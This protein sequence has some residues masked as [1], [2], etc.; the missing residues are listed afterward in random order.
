M[1]GITKPAWGPLWE[2]TPFYSKAVESIY[3]HD[4]NKAKQLLDAAGW[5]PGRDG[6]RTKNGRR[7]TVTLTSSDFTK[8]FEEVS[9]ANWKDVGIELQLQPMTVAAA[10]EAIQNNKVNSSPQAWV[11]SDPVVLTNLFHSKNIKGGFAWSKYSDPHLDQL[12]DSGEH[13]IHDSERATIYAEVQKIIMDNAL[14]VPYYGNPEA[15][16]AYE[17][18][19]QGVKQDFRNYLWLYDTH[20]K[21]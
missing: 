18:R 15:S 2:T 7:L 9:Q 8:P 1:F 12:L 4:P 6:I 16:T 19:Y 14:I 17:S 10:F 20:L 13:T 21:A 11:S 5:V 3:S